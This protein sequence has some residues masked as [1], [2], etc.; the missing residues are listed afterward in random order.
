M[1]NQLSGRFHKFKSLILLSLILIPSFLACDFL[2][3]LVKT[4]E[5]P[6][7]YNYTKYPTEFHFTDPYDSDHPDKHSDAWW[8]ITIDKICPDKSI[9]INS[10][11]ITKGTEFDNE[12]ASVR[13]R[14][15]YRIGK[16][17]YIDYTFL[18]QNSEAPNQWVSDITLLPYE[19]GISTETSFSIYLLWLIFPI[20][21]FSKEDAENIAWLNTH[22]EKLD[23]EIEGTKY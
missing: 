18:T 21:E 10:K 1:Q 22:M 23:I 15:I 6:F 12:V 14:W 2:E 16:K 13:L 17:N 19:L 20:D 4:C 11:L 3:D 8:H 7:T 9:T 5:E